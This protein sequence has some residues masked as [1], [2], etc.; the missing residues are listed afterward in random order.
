MS[1]KRDTRH[2]RVIGNL[3]YYQ[4]RVPSLL[5]DDPQFVGKQ[6]FIVPLGTDSHAIALQKRN[7]WNVWFDN[8]RKAQ[9]SDPLLAEK[10]EQLKGMSQEELD[11][12]LEY[13]SQT[14]ASE[15]S[16]IDHPEWDSNNPS[17]PDMSESE[18]LNYIALQLA[19]G[20]RLTPEEQGVADKAKMSLEYACEKIMQE[21]ETDGKDRKTIL[22]YKRASDLFHQYLGKEQ[23]IMDDIDRGMVRDFLDKCK[24]NDYHHKTIKGWF[25]NLGV[26]W[27]YVGDYENFEKRNP[28]RRWSRYFNQESTSYEAWD[29]DHLIEVVK[30]SET[31]LDKLMIYI[32]WYSGARLDEVFDL[33]AKSIKKDKDTGIECF[34]FKEFKKGKNKY[35]K[36]Q[37]PIH[38]NLKKMLKGFK[39]FTHRPSSDACSKTF[40]RAKTKAGLSYL[41]KTFAFHSLRSNVETALAN[42]KTPMYMIDGILG[43]KIG[44][45][46]FSTYFGEFNINVLLEEVNKLP[47]L[48]VKEEAKIN[49]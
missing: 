11:N 17:T 41:G 38:N 31:D 10:K 44:E 4:R 13:W 34:Y 24:Q 27:E 40:G 16:Y 14:V 5:K 2:L 20:K 25:S 35:A 12:Y 1:P 28:F 8:K 30:A 18:K 21:L 37:I 43:H 49:I 42:N 48:D 6:M 47:A 3:Y 9:A 23:I 45:G 39:G 32:G 36:R 33:N 7:K 29:P 46:E 15:Y 26:C 19:R 22:K